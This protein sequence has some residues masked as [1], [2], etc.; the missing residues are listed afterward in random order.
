MRIGPYK[1]SVVYDNDFDENGPPSFEQFSD[2][3]AGPTVSDEVR[4]I[5][6]SE[7]LSDEAEFSDEMSLLDQVDAGLLPDQLAH[8]EYWDERNPEDDYGTDDDLE[9][10]LEQCPFDIDELLDNVH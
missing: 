6:D 7:R 3:D 10:A 4:R 9:V 2:L 5:W 1:L 8:A